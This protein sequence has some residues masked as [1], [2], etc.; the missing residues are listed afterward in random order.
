MSTFTVDDNHGRAR[1]V[2]ANCFIL[3]LSSQSR[4]F[5]VLLVI[6]WQWQMFQM[7]VNSFLLHWNQQQLSFKWVENGAPLLFPWIGSKRRQGS[8]SQKKLS[9]HHHWCC[10]KPEK[11]Y[12]TTNPRGTSP[13]IITTPRQQELTPLQPQMINN[14]PTTLRDG[15]PIFT[16]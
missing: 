16:E 15:G 7:N 2:C 6:N 1:L 14:N 8:F 11:C 13:P 3:S 9:F 4:S 12:L 5:A 10:G